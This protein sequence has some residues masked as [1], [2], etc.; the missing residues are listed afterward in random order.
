MKKLDFVQIVGLLANLGVIAGIV[1]LGL[2][3]RQNNSLL[4]AQ[5]SFARFSV[6]RERRTRLLE[7]RAG[8]LETVIKARSGEELSRIER[9]Q[10]T[11]HWIDVLDSWLWQFRESQAGRIGDGLV[12]VATWRILW[13][14]DE[15]F[16]GTYRNIFA[17]RDAE[18]DRYMEE[19]IIGSSR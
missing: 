2:E 15:G 13:S 9:A 17:N 16:R 19:N 6:E 12:D 3:L 1:F 18:F 14:Q 5:T 10:L 8:L 11:A 4:E 7:N